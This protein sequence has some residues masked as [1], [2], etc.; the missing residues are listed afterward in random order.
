MPIE[1]PHEATSAKKNQQ[2]CPY[3]RALANKSIYYLSSGGLAIR[4]PQK[5]LQLKV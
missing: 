1:L 5:M 3:T 4:H 2:H